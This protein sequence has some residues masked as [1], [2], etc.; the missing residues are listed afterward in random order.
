MFQ[1]S[2]KKLFTKKESFLLCLIEISTLVLIHLTLRLVHEILLIQINLFFF[3]RRI[4]VKSLTKKKLEK[5]NN[6]VRHIK[7]P[8]K[9]LYTAKEL[10]S[11]KNILLSSDIRYYRVS[12]L[13]RYLCKF[14]GNFSV[15]SNEL[16][17]EQTYSKQLNSVANNSQL[18][19]LLLN[20]LCRDVWGR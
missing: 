2:I 8:R 19:V 7:N 3:F 15:V 1:R 20:W 12:S 4:Y 18:A 11:S 13:V 10:I 14:S 5:K 16:Q 6:Y 17:R 9:T